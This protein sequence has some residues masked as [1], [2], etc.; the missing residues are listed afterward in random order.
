MHKKTGSLILGGRRRLSIIPFGPMKIIR[1][2]TGVS[3]IHCVNKRKVII[4]FL[5]YQNISH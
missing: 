3:T 5:F 1:V 2:R 4:T